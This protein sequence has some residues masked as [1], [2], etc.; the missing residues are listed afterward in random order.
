MMFLH[1]K[2][3]LFR[4][5]LSRARALE[6]DRHAYR[7]DRTQCHATFVDR[8]IIYTLDILTPTSRL[9]PCYTVLNVFNRVTFVVIVVNR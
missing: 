6:T 1:T 8:K 4:S 3:E 7:R 9:C 5:R 2:N